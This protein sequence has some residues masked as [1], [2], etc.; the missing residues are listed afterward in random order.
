MLRAFYIFL[1]IAALSAIGVWLADNPGQLV[2]HWRGYEIRTSFVI[3]IAL[4]AFVAFLALFIYRLFVSAMSSPAELTRYFH[5][6]R[7]KK[8]FLALSRGM[9]AVAAGDA[10]DAKRFAKDA[11]ELLDAPEMTLLLSA[12]AAQLEGDDKAAAGYFRQMMVSPET[13]FLGLRGLFVQAKR[14][15][16]RDEALKIARRAFKLRPNTPW[17]AQAVFELEAAEEN[18]N[19]ALEVLDAEL[20][21]KLIDRDKARRRRAVLLTARA[22]EAEVAAHMQAGDARRKA[23]G[24]AYRLASEALSLVPYFPPAMA[25]A[26]RAAAATGRARKAMSLVRD[27]WAH[28]PHPDLASAWLEMVEGESAYDRLSRAQELEKLAPDH[29]ESHILVARAAI[30]ARDWQGA[31][32]ALDMFTG[33][34]AEE[35]PTRRVCELMAEIEEGEFGNRGSSRGWLSRALHAPDDPQWVGEGYRSPRWSP[36]NPV[37]GEFDA[38]VWATPAVRLPASGM[39][40]GAAAAPEDVRETVVT[41]AVEPEPFSAPGDDA[42]DVTEK[43]RSPVSQP[44]ASPAGAD[45]P[46]PEKTESK[47]DNKVAEGVAG[48]KKGPAKDAPKDTSKDEP[49]KDDPLVI[50]PPVP[51]DPGPE[52]DEDVAQ[53]G[54]TR[55]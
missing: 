5:D 43:V 19:A 34:S 39:P 29:S 22:Q 21:A 45:K 25:L 42:R 3:G 23:F 7:Q 17:A 8:G 51:D 55:W 47:P 6:R 46:S 50:V 2:M 16:D 15:G 54:S 33:P 11:R 40:G 24:R 1:V 26:V 14:A 4:L 18:W 52:G 44:A 53:E 36:I 20:S 48:P 30:G 28:E 13:E 49:K 9:V 38:L 35:T 37:T 31:R 41:E 10:G 12:Q 27:G 32:K